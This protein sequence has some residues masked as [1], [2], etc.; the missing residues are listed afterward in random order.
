MNKLAQVAML[1]P[2]I[3]KVLLS[4][5][6]QETAYPLFTISSNIPGLYLKCDHVYF[7]HI[8]SSS[9]IMFYSAS[10]CCSA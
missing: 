4:N 9:V 7:L 2:C 6:R 5:H 8:L 10:Y 3:Q 1:V